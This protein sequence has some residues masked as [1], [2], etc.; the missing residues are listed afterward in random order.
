[1]FNEKY[2]IWLGLAQVMIGIVLDTKEVMYMGVLLYSLGH[3]IEDNK[4]KN[5][6]EK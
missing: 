3:C 5:E 2:L 6:V 1:M 4:N